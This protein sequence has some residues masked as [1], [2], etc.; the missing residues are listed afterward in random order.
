[1]KN[2]SKILVVDDFE[3]NILLLKTILSEAG[4]SV[5]MAY[6]GGEALTLINR[7]KPDLILLDILMPGLSGMEVLEKIKSDEITK[8]I[9]VIMI[10]AIHELKSVR[11]AMEQG[12]CDYIKKPIIRDELLDKIS[13]VLNTA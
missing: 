10:T 11:Y 13:G 1:M 5:K 12:A 9:P 7:E 4:F 8:N 2:S 3:T 6:S